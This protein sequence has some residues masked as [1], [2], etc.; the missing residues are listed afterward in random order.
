MGSNDGDIYERPVHTVILDGFEMSVYE[1]T[2]GVY[3]AIMGENLSYFSGDDNLPAEQVTW[4]DAV[5][6]CNRL[7]DKAGLDRCY[8]GKTWNCDFSKNGFRLPTE[9]EWEYSCRA[10]TTTKYYIPEITTL[11]Y[12][13]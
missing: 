1:I 13:A 12:Y 3:K 9:A 2:Q 8:D 7:S 4:Y 5:K 10:G 6:F 11:P